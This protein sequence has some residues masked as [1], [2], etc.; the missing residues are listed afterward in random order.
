M[1]YCID[2][3][4][5][6]YLYDDIGCDSIGDFSKYS[7]ESGCCGFIIDDSKAVLFPKPK[8]K[9]LILYVGSNGEQMI[10]HSTII[11]AK[12]MT[13]EYIEQVF[14]VNDLENHNLLKMMI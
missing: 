3:L 6:T 4:H 2:L 14:D 9:Y 7:R 12:K 11:Q 10:T 13:E 5:K 1:Y 8:K